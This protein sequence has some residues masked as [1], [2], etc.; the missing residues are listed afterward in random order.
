MTEK[1]SKASLNSNSLLAYK[2]LSDAWDKDPGDNVFAQLM[3]DEL[4]T[5]ATSISLLQADPVLA[6]HYGGVNLNAAE[7]MS[8]VLKAK[9]GELDVKGRLEPTA[10][11]LLLNKYTAES[12][13][14][15]MPG[16]NDAVALGDDGA[17]QIGVKSPAGVAIAREDVNNPFN[18]IRNYLGSEN[19][20]G[21]VNTNSKKGSKTGISKEKD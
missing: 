3:K 1:G 5:L 8:D 19:A 20:V 16:A 10:Q 17:L 14:P 18:M 13:L 2:L 11:A 21:I 6:M 12:Q 9:V 7:K 15:L 4:K